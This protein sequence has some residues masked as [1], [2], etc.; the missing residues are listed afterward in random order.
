M[1]FQSSAQ[2]KIENLMSRCVYLVPFV[3]LECH[4]QSIR[5]NYTVI[6]GNSICNDIPKLVKLQESISNKKM[7]IK[8]TS[9]T[10]ISS[11]N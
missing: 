1:L 7:P 9:F 10:D 11:Q 3:D 6:P 4:H 2:C 5:R 8:L